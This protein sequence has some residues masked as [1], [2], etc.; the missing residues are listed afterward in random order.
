MN[1][2]YLAECLV[3][4]FMLWGFV[5]LIGRYAREAARVIIQSESKRLDALGHLRVV[6]SGIILTCS[7]LLG[8]WLLA[9]LRVILSVH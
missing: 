4:G 6:A 3:L 5:M 9:A 7:M 1:E 2:L 8:Y